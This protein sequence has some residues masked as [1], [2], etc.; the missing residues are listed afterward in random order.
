VR[1]AAPLVE[2]RL[3]L[4]YKRFFADVA[5]AD[6]S[7]VTAHCPNPGAMIGLNAPGLP[8]FLST[9]SNP[10]RRL[11]ATLEL[12]AVDGH[13]VGINTMLPNGL[14]AEALARGAIAPLAGYDRVRREVRYGTNSRV[15]FVLERGEVAPPSP[16]SMLATQAPL[17]SARPAGEGATAYVEVKNVHLVRRPGLAEFPDCVTVRGARHL[18]EL[19]ILAA[20]GVR[21][22]LLFVIQREDVAAVDV[23]RDLDPAY[24]RAYD[25]ARAAGVEVLACGCR[26]TCEAIEIVRTLPV[27]P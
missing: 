21:A 17:G 24:A 10:K 3:V 19:A 16:A 6:G 8:A 14:V 9:S 1:F 27:V 4:R 20:A 7:V 2:G 12:V 26:V 23:A 18:D 15:D 5:L 22:V 11:A 13:L 25:R